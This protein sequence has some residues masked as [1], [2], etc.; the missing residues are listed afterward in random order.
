VREIVETLVLTVLIFLIL[1]FVIQSYHVEG[2]SMQPNFT[3]DQLVVVNKTAYMFQSPQRGDVIVFHDPQDPSQ[4][5]IKRIIGLPGDN[6]DINATDVRVNGVLLD[7]H[8]YISKPQNYVAKSW[9]VPA[10]EYFVLGDNRPISDDSRIW[11]YVP[12]DYIIGKAI[13]VYWPLTDWHTINT[14]SPTYQHIKSAR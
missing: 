4:D 5:F 6:I 3:S 8:N 9:K 14:Y 2:T 10:N 1:H 11:G 12:K 13:F 7:E